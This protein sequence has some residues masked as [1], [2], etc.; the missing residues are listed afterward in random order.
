MGLTDEQR[1]ARVRELVA[2]K[3]AEAAEREA[4]KRRIAEDAVS[5]TPSPRRTSCQLWGEAGVAHAIGADARTSVIR[6]RLAGGA[7]PAA[8]ARERRRARRRERPP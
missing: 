1:E 7:P 3:A 5:A 8:G 4:V 2:K 6:S